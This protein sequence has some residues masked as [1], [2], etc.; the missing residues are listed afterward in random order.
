MG[1][2]NRE[3]RRAK[4]GDRARAARSRSASNGQ[5]AGHGPFRITDTPT[6][7]TTEERLADLIDAA[8]RAAAEQADK[9][10]LVA[11]LVAAGP[12]IG[13]R[14]L[15]G[16]LLRHRMRHSLDNLRRRHWEDADL[17]EVVRRQA[18]MAAA[19]LVAEPEAIGSNSADWQAGI[20]AAIDALGVLDC[21]PPLE[22]LS[23]AT[24]KMSTAP[25]ADGVSADLLRKVR[26]LLAKAEST[27]FSEEADALNAKAAELM[28][29][30]RIDRSALEAGLPEHDAEIAARRIWI[31]DPYLVPKRILLSVVARSNGCEAVGT[32]LGY[33]T[34]VGHPDDISMTELLF[35]SLLVQ[36]TR[37]MTA[38]GK[39]A[40]SEEASSRAR[41]R[42][43]ADAFGN[44]EPIDAE[45]ARAATQDMFG[46]LKAARRRS[47]SF[48]RSFLVAFANRIGSRLSEANT[49]A[50]EAATAEMGGAFLPVLASQQAAV[51]RALGVMFGNLTT[52]KI[53]VTDH[54]GYA[55]GVAAADLADLGVRDRLSTT[56]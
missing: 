17:F 22:D 47:P 33:S 37:Q 36:A 31:D 32:E 41:L 30:Y 55:A 54:E 38:I 16:S 20:R 39:A 13:G 18:T 25:R 50:T 14:A 42:H 24:R 26:A 29:R 52:T 27:S 8:A 35:T 28:T 11:R 9:T 56:G 6:L 12:E 46:G 48:R 43:L 44:G 49:A 53:S 1:K 2:Q 51:D 34:V 7:T 45:E 19:R 23:S 3:R 10:A 21:L 5:A 4:K 15:V 40:K